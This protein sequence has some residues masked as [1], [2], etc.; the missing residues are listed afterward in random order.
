MHSFFVLFYDQKI[1][2]GSEAVSF[3][4]LPSCFKWYDGGIFL[5]KKS[6]LQSKWINTFYN[7]EQAMKAYELAEK[8]M[9]HKYSWSKKEANW[10]KLNVAVLQQMESRMDAL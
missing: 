2:A 7:K 9:N 4:G 3:V 5:Q 8:L 10:L 6:E 1:H